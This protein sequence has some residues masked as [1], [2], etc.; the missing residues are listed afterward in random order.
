MA[1]TP[2]TPRFGVN[3]DVTPDK[4]NSVGIS[5]LSLPKTGG[6]FAETHFMYNPAQVSRDMGSTQG[7]SPKGGF[8]PVEHQSNY[9]CNHDGFFGG[10]NIVI[11]M[12]EHKVLTNTIWSQGI[13]YAEMSPNGGAPALTRGKFD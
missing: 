1:G 8:E 4:T 2:G 3:P 9:M 7:G 5:H 6:D 13:E 10:S 12:D 11:N